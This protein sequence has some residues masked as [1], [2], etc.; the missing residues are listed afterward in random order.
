MPRGMQTHVNFYV[1]DLDDAVSKWTKLFAILDPEVAQ[2][3]PVYL[4]S[5]EGDTATRTATFVNPNGLELQLT[6]S[7]A[8]AKD[9]NFVDHVDHIHFATVDV[10]GKFDA[11]KKAG[12]RINPFTLHDEE[13]ATEVTTAEGVMPE[14]QWQKWCLGPLPG[15]VAVE[16]AL[17]YE[18]VEG[19]WKPVKNWSPDERYGL[20]G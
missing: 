12:F 20:N 8:V 2:R 18:P 6:C 10:E 14:V 17:P 1:K 19:E 4:N 15:N 11:I 5:G 3:K 16:V 7:V 13:E 9:P